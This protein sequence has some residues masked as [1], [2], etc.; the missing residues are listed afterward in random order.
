MKAIAVAGLLGLTI[1]VTGCATQDE[2]RDVEKKVQAETPVAQ[3]ESFA[4]RGANIF[5]KAQN[6]SEEQREQLMLIHTSTFEKTA[7]LRD[8]ITKTKSA[9]FKTVVN[10][11][12]SPKEISMMKNRIVKLDRERLDVMLSAF[13]EVQ[14]VMGRNQPMDPNIFEP[15][16]SMDGERR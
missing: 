9:L 5:L 7:R 12:A 14:K 8:E 11:K 13:D 16:M 6:L 10:P 3:D 4:N 1:L 15:F 2:K